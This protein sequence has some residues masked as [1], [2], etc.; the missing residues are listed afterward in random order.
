MRSRHVALILA[1]GMTAGG[2]FACDRDPGVRTYEAP[3]ETPRPS[4]PQP[5]AAQRAEGT[6]PAWTL[7]AGWKQLP[8][9]NQFRFATIQVDASDPSLVLTV[10]PLGVNS[11]G[12]LANVNRWRGEVGLPSIQEAELN[13]SVQHVDA[14]DVHIDVVDVA[15][16]DPRSQQTRRTLGAVVTRPDRTWYFKMTG[17]GDKVGAQKS[18]FDAFIKSIRFV[19]SNAAVPQGA[20]GPQPAQGGADPHAGMDMTTGRPAA[21][22]PG[23]PAP[24]AASNATWTA[25]KDW[26]QDPTPRDMRLATFHVGEGDAKTE[27]QV[28]KFPVATFSNDPAG[29]INR[30]RQQVGLAPAENPA[31]AN[32]PQ[33]VTVADTPGYLFDLNNPANGK[34]QLVAM[35]QRGEEI[36]YFK[37]LGPAR[38]VT[39][40]K[41][42]FETFLKSVQF[43]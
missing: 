10:I 43:K 39:D 35:L 3:K 7:P 6:T 42:A 34:R 14:N 17:P 2:L 32:A 21:G 41:P 13:N 30:W 9:D 16:S 15:G 36:W 26:K 31:A 29:N 20:I 18:N 33:A 8:G 19:A 12:L 38:T 4:Q 40:Q 5:Q 1:A 37:I 25:P 23:S 11:G 28:S 27:V 22:T 24:A